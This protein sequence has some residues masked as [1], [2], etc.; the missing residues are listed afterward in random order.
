MYIPIYDL[1][2]F[3]LFAVI[4]SV[5]GYLIL[6]LHRTF[7]VL[8]HVRGILDA[9][10]DDISKIIS[11]LP[12]AL[13]NVNALTVSLKKSADFTTTAFDSLQ[14]NFIDT[15]DDV[16]DGLEIFV[17]YAK[18]IGEVWRAVFSKNG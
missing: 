15:V 13:E 6:V 9:H 18:V 5:S 11:G 16:R 1:G 17:V 4:L 12:E 14:S 10:S 3:I 2:L 8:G 7:C